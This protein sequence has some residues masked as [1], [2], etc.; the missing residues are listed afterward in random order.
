[1]STR[2]EAMA[3]PSVLPLSTLLLTDVTS[4]NA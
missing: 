3:I 2:K 1:M 4:S